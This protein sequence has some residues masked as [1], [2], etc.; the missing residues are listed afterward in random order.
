MDQAPAMGQCHFVRHRVIPTAMS[1]IYVCI[2]V[3]FNS[4]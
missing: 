1:A 3:G 2:K 4:L